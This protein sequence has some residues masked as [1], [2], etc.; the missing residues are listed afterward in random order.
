MK[1]NF[2]VIVVRGGPVGLTAAHALRQANIRFIVV[3]RRAELYEDVGASLVLRP[4]TLRVMHQLGLLEK[5]RKIGVGIHT[6]RSFT[7]Q[8]YKFRATNEIFPAMQAKF[9]HSR[10]RCIPSPPV[11]SPLTRANSHGILPMCFHRAHLVQAFYDGLDDCGKAHIHT[12]KNV[13]Q[14]EALPSG[15]R[16]TCADGSTYRGDLVVG[17]DGVHSRVRRL[18]REQALKLDPNADVNPE[19]PYTTHYRAMWFTFPR[20]EGCLPGEAA[21]THADK[22]SVQFLCGI[23]R[24]WM[25]L[26]EKL[27][28]P[29][30][31]RR[32]YTEADRRE[33]RIK[34]EDMAVTEKY[35][36]KDLFPARFTEGMADLEEG[37][38]QHWYWNR[39]VLVGDAC[40]KVTPN[41]GLGYNN[42]LQDVATLVNRLHALLDDA[43]GESPTS[44]A[45]AGALD[46]YQAARLQFA[47]DD[48]WLSGMVTRMWAWHNYVYWVLDRYILPN[49]P[50]MDYWVAK[51]AGEAGAKGEVLDYVAADEPF[52]GKIPWV[53]SIPRK[54]SRSSV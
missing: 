2:K 37:M 25:F 23:D 24:A 26:Y 20:P 3:E 11:H 30:Q 45:L 34:F 54:A 8:G 41:L 29:T 43:P 16:V 19:K 35:K 28:E 18:M 44:E 47:P 5:L 52:T 50:G 31:E 36:V 22:L 49:L 13:T 42:G 12:G 17:A 15:V 53:H 21:D 9:V 10:A 32:S 6:S 48:L 7:A 39:I 40:H 4:P 33:Y 46:Q 27:D 51:S 38:V 1:S 14:V